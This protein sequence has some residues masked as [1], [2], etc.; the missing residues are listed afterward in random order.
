M[1][2]ALAV[3]ASL[4][5]EA[6]AQSSISFDKRTLQGTSSLNAPTS[7]QFGPDGRLYVSQQNGT[8]FAYTISRSSQGSYS[9]TASETINAVKNIT[10][11]DDDGSVNS[12]VT[13]RLITGLLVTGTGQNPV[14]YVTSSDP[15]IGGGANSLDHNLDTNSGILSRLTKSGSS[16]SKVDL[17]RGMPRSE[18]NH[19]PNGMALSADGDTL[20]IAYGGHTNMGAPSNNFVFLPEYALSAAIL[21]IDLGAIGNSTYNLPTLDD[22]NRS[23]SNDANDPFGGNNGKN[24]A[25]LV[26]GGPVQVYAPGFRNPYDVVITEAGRMYTVDNGPNSGW[27]DVPVGEGTNNC[28]NGVS[29]PGPTYQ[30]GLHHVTGRGYYG[31]HPNPTRARTANTFNSSNPQSPVSTNNSVECDYRVPGTQDGSL[32][33]FKRSTNGIVEYT[34]SNFGG[35]MRG[36]LIIASFDNQIWRVELNSSGTAVSRAAPLFSSVG[37]KPLDVTAQG[38]GVNFPGTIWVAD[39]EFD[40]IFAYEPAD[41]DVCTGADDSGLDEDDD[42]FDNAD[43]IENGTDPCS[44][45]DVPPDW[46]GDFQ[47]DRNDRDDDND[48]MFDYEDPFA[49]DPQNGAATEVPFFYGWEND[50]PFAGGLLDLGFTGLMTNYETG[51]AFLFDADDMTAGGAAGVV[52]VDGATDGDALGSNNDQEYGFQVGAMFAPGMDELVARTRVVAPFRGIIPEPNQSLGLFVGNGDQDNYF[53]IVIEAGEDD[54]AAISCLLE[55]DGTVLPGASHPVIV[56]GPAGVDLYIAIDRVASTVRAGYALLDGGFIGDVVPLGGALPIPSSWIDDPAIGFAVGIISTSRG[57][58]GRFPATWDFLELGQETIPDPT[59]TTTTTTTSSTTT[60][61]PPTTTT[62]IVTT[63][64][65]PG[66]T[67]TLPA[68]TSTTL[69]N[70]TSTTTTTTLSEGETCGDADGNGRISVIDA[71]MALRASIGA[72]PCEVCVCDVNGNGVVGATDAFL[73]LRAAVGL[74]EALFC[75]ACS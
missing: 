59:T 47:S 15:R 68:T 58:G 71:L 1:A 30:D 62:V 25:K 37:S 69:S 32:M 10:N 75:E 27:G 70:A 14:L 21:E 67:T 29:E 34:A 4:C 55:V 49:V 38:D 74:D 18:E 31:G 6:R 50:D 22:E 16:W 63:T 46:D 24:Q 9:V 66:S 41:L 64:T 72:S 52:T 23:G 48:G 51:Y 28:T 42:G 43:E 12:G 26:P 7:L 40:M 53:K 5:G 57:P 56:P 65:L 3:L 20:Y 2:T 45:A 19:G 8:I 11:H 61:V 73:V 33:T 60:T 17:V 36:D 35:Q 54:T 13:N 39:H 44:A